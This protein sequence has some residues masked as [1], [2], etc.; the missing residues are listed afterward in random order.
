MAD[1]SQDGGSLWKH[2]DFWR[3]WAAQTSSQVATAIG[4]TVIPL[5]AVTVL[6]ATPLE[7]GVL[8]GA[9]Y[10]AF[11]LLGLPA[12]AWVDR[13]RRR[14]IMITSDLARTALMLS[15]PVAWWSGVLTL[16]QLIVVGALV[17]L[18]TVLFDVSY[19]SYLP[20]LVGRARL[21]D[22]NAKLQASQ[23]I[24][25]VGG[26]SGG[27]GLA[28]LLGAANAMVAMGAGYLAS[29][30]FVWRIRTPEARPEPS[31]A[32]NLR[33]EIGEGLR[34]I[35]RVPTLRAIVA[36]TTTSNF[37]FTVL[38]TLF[39]LFL[40][41]QLRLGP[42]QIGLVMTCVGAGGLLGALTVGWW[43]RWVGQVRTIW[44]S[45]LICYQFGL[46]I[47]LAG[48]GTAALLAAIGY[49][50]I[51]YGIVVFNVGSVSYR[52]T[53]CPEHLLGRMNA[54]FRFFVWGVAPIGGF[55][56]G[57]L[58]EW[59]GVRDTLWL[60]TLGMVLSVL[61]LLLSPLRTV[62]DVPTNPMTPA[63]S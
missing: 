49:G 30:V 32:R 46:L 4:L 15:V 17:G 9:E 38:S 58:G 57:A 27:G 40:S 2:G 51:G 20:G 10:A 25:R 13:V 31:T 34:F 5:L 47:P 59:L 54:T 43:N 48:T 19:Q 6:A 26:P 62:R 56:G 55:L 16:T 52:Q 50:M 14:P 24:A 3:L 41:R 45:P 12:G 42:A 8:T 37:C 7:M 44:L 60:A 22:G 63:S 11:L 28:Q 39:V 18:C 33:A 36:S 29:A 23:S 21:V 53:I 35:A 61:F 1:T